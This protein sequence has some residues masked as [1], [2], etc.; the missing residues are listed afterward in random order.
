VT[1]FRR[2]MPVQKTCPQAMPDEDASG[3]ELSREKLHQG[4]LG[5]TNGEEMCGNLSEGKPNKCE[6][7]GILEGSARGIRNTRGETI[8][9]KEEIKKLA[10]SERVR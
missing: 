1:S 10:K 4:V 7:G 8:D 6:R 5:T 9:D 3:G 2:P